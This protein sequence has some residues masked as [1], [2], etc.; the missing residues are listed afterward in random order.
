M[1]NNLLNLFERPKF[2]PPRAG[3]LKL[4][5]DASDAST[6]TK[7][8][9]N[10]AATA[11]GTSGTTTITASA[12]QANLIQVGERIR[13][14][15]ID[16][17]TVASVSTVTI[18]TVETLTA[19]Y[20]AGSALALERVSQWNDKSSNGYNVTQATALKQP[21]YNPNQQNSKAV[22]TFDGAS[23]FAVPAG[24]FTIP[25]GDNTAFFVS[26]RNSE[27]GAQEILAGMREAGSVRYQLRY[28]SGAGSIAFWNSNAA[29]GT[30]VSKS[31]NTNTN[32]N[33][34]IARRSSTTL[35][36]AVNNGPETT[37]TNAN[38]ESGVDSAFI[39]TTSD[40]SGWLIG[41]IAE[42][43]IYHRSLTTFEISQVNRYLSQ[44][45]GVT[46]S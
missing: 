10:Q 15:G 42:I 2:M 28:T 7:A 3:D 33:I 14:G 4:W 19:T 34:N 18:T 24:V 22:L 41:S 37:N 30:E 17:Y 5:L 36:A 12:T 32:M 13:I 38:S 39:G 27:T 6:I 16:I 35:A 23:S 1:S 25:N 11:S 46:I 31:G 8:Y 26:K 44:K 29:P 43:I 9:Q 45:W 20:G 21:V 40:A